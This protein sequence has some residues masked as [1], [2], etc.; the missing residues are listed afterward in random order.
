MQNSA[1]LKVKKWSTFQQFR[2]RNPPWIKLYAKILQDEDFMALSPNSKSILMLAWLIASE[3]ADGT[4]PASPED[5]SEKMH[6]NVT[7]DDVNALIVAG[8]LIGDLLPGTDSAICNNSNSNN[9]CNNS[10]SHMRNTIATDITDRVVTLV[11]TTYV[12]SLSQL[13]IVSSESP[14]LS[15]VPLSPKPEP[16]WV[17]VNYFCEKTNTHPRKDSVISKHIRRAQA[18]LEEGATL[19]QLLACV[20][21]AMAD[22]WW[23]EKG[24]YKSPVAIWKDSDR[25]AQLSAMQP[26]SG[27]KKSWLDI[28]D[29]ALRLNDVGHL[30]E[31]S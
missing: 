25:V 30:P 7:A 22:K 9:S 5:L 14:Q 19:E 18:R 1:R 12:E 2:H 16:A 23:R 13:D 29:E 17:A 27:N 6:Q 4:I 11:D 20:D 24:L 28:M 15:L 8:F 31:L 21:N 3:S 10:K 26:N